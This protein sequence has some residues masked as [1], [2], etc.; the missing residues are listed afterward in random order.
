L[1]ISIGHHFV[2]LRICCYALEYYGQGNNYQTAAANTK[3]TVVNN[4]Y[5]KASL[6]FIGGTAAKNMA[7]GYLQGIRALNVNIYNSGSFLSR[8]PRTVLALK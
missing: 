1:Q 6:V 2:D 8:R 5:A 4:D 7:T 3:P